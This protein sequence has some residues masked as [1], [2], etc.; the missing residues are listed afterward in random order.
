[1]LKVAHVWDDFV[2]NSFIEVQPLLAKHHFDVSSITITRTLRDN[3][4]GFTDNVFFHRQLSHELWHKPGFFTK[5]K[6][7]L[8]R[9]IF[10]FS[11]LKFAK[12]ILKR[13]NVDL[14]HFHFGFTVAQYPELGDERP[15]LVAFYGSDISAALQSAYWRSRYQKILPKAALLLVL[16]E[17]VKRRLESLG[18]DSKK[19]RIW[20]LPAGV[21]KYPLR[22]PLEHQ[23]RAR[24]I[25]TARFVEKK[26]HGLLL[27]AFSLLA[28]KR[29]N[30]SA[31][32]LGYGGGIDWVRDELSRRGLNDKV[33]VIDTKAKGDFAAL[34]Y[35]LL[36]EHDIFVLP[37]ITAKSGDDEA[38]SL[39]KI[40]PA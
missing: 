38:Q 27:E 35:S 8:D 23:G 32:L 19:I 4:S 2:C 22:T 1:M 31:T 40:L 18:C 6:N 21:E 30:F 37:S 11:F 14:V 28:E 20:N 3:G 24:L 25:T 36:Q 26:G 9:R 13:E 10:R 12:R 16:C 7:F 34:H 5:I 17:E 33:T 29:V 15:F 39:H